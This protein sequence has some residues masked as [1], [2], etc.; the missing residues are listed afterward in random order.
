MKE[1]LEIDFNE[2]NEWSDE[3]DEYFLKPSF[4]TRRKI[5]M[6]C[7]NQELKIYFF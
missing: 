6:W 2:P 4:I 1:L 7:L 5:W 3:N